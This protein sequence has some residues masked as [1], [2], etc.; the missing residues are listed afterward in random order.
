MYRKITSF[1]ETWKESRH[2]EPLV[3]IIF[4]IWWRRSMTLRLV[5]LKIM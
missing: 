4:C 5:W 1:L 3:Q 2:R